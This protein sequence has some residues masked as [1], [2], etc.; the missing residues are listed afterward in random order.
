[1]KEVRKRKEILLSFVTTWHLKI[2][3]AGSSYMHILFSIKIPKN[4]IAEYKLVFLQFLN[5][6][7]LYFKWEWSTF[8]NYQLI[9]FVSAKILSF[10]QTKALMFLSKEDMTLLL[11]ALKLC[12]MDYFYNL[13]PSWNNTRDLNCVHLILGSELKA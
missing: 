5:K 7:Q 9:S 8:V 10:P 6:V 2:V 4:N 1:M 12:W 13:C 11:L 3:K